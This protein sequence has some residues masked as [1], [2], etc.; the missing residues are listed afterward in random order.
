M[1]IIIKLDKVLLVK[2]LVLNLVLIN[3]VKTHLKLV[4]LDKVIRQVKMVLALL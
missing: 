1:K 3:K 2:T 4:L